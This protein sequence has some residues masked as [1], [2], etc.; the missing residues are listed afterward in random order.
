VSVKLALSVPHREVE[1]G[2]NI[3]LAKT[4]KAKIWPSV[5][6]DNQEQRSTPQVVEEEASAE[7]EPEV[8]RYKKIF[9][10]NQPAGA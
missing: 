3:G 10:M 9:L 6:P 1:I 2:I 7:D 8:V 4:L 5:I